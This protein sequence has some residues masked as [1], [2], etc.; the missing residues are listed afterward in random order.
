VLVPDS[1]VPRVAR[2]TWSRQWRAELCAGAVEGVLGVGSFTAMRSLGAPDWI[3]ALFVSFGQILW[4]AAPAWEAAF[5]RFHFRQAFLWM[6]LAAN[7]PM[8][9]VALVDDDALARGWGLWLFAGV[10]VIAAAVDAAYVPHRGAL[11]GANYPLAVRGR[12]FATLS[13][14]SRLS[15]VVAAKTS[16]WLL[17]ADFRW[18]RVLFPVAGVCGLL[19]HWALSRIRWQRAGVPKMRAWRGIGTASAAAREAWR[20]T[21]RVLR[22]DR[23]FRTYEIGFLLYGFGFLMSNPLVT[24]YAVH[25]LSLSY[26]EWTT[27]NGLAQPVAYVAT[28]L[29]F[30]RAVDRFGVVRTTA[31]AFALLTLFF[32][33]MPFVRDA[34]ALDVCY[35]LFGVAMALVNLGWTLGP[36]EFAPPGQARTYSTVHVLFV[37]LRSAI[38][39]FLGWWLSTRIGIAAVFCISAVLVAAG[40]ATML[41]LHRARR[42]D[43]R[44][45]SA[46]SGVPPAP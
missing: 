13:T 17:D 12:I 36:L 10:I 24:V 31:A 5:A 20:D 15:T 22:E 2:Y 7:A 23:W 26:G 44:S 1:S 40:C 28:I 4:L 38:A 19:E 35:L 42:A 34:G 32:T 33:S 6:G 46:P 3:A 9:L 14:V 21:S 43:Q 29:A 41:R 18:I 37:G 16:G 25:D 11:A 45:S 8:L 30:G 39:P 27:A